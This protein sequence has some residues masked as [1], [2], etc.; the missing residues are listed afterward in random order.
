MPP[1]W[2]A[3]SGGEGGGPRR[4]LN[5]WLTSQRRQRCCSQGRSQNL[6]Y[7]PKA[8]VRLR[9]MVRGTS[10][11]RIMN[12]GMKGGN[13]RQAGSAGLVRPLSWRAA[14]QLQVGT[15]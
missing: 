1:G 2:A 13:G 9:Q 3:H 12:C 10:T 7:L 14:R 15:V 4:R 11:G 5:R 8:T 6:S